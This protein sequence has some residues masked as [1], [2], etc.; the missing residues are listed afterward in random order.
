FLLIN[1]AAKDMHRT[2]HIETSVTNWTRLFGYYSADKKTPVPQEDLPLLKAVHGKSVDN[3]EM[4]LP[5]GGDMEEG[6]WISC[7]ARPLRSDKG[8]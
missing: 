7:T 3:V 1:Q 4:Y 5:L 6:L 2:S 8:V